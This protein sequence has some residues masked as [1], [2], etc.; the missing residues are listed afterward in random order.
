MCMCVRGRAHIT[1]ARVCVCSRARTSTCT[2]ERE[3][4]QEK[5]TRN[6]KKNPAHVQSQWAYR[7]SWLGRE[8]ESVFSRARFLPVIYM[9]KRIYTYIY[10]YTYMYTY[11]Y[12]YI[13]TYIYIYI[14]T[15]ICMCFLTRSLSLYCARTI[16]RIRMAVKRDSAL[17]STR[18]QKASA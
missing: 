15:Y 2:C 7:Y 10:I 12:T 17:K 8:T 14:R 3:S 6:S 4:E 16:E 1:I 18:A 13:Y 5:E 9:Y 11:T